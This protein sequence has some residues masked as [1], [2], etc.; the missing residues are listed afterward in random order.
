[1]GEQWHF[2]WRG[3]QGG[4][5]SAARLRQMADDGRLL[6]TDLVW[7]KGM[8]T[9]APAGSLHGLFRPR[10]VQPPPPPPVRSV[11]ATARQAYQ[12]LQIEGN[13]QSWGFWLGVIAA[14]VAT[15]FTWHFTANT[16]VTI[17]ASVVALAVGAYVGY[18]FALV[19]TGLLVLALLV[20][21]VLLFVH[22]Q[23]AKQAQEE[24]VF[25]PNSLETT[26]LWLQA[27]NQKVRE[28]DQKNNQVLSKE[29]LE[30][31][32]RELAR[33]E[34]AEVK[35][36]ALVESVG[37]DA[38]TLQGPSVA[39]GLS[40]TFEMTTET[41]RP[42]G[43]AGARPLVL[44]ITPERGRNLARGQAVQFTGRVLVCR[45]ERSGGGLTFTLVV[46]EAR[47]AE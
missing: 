12:G 20:G 24:A 23:K 26:V 44:P 30:G 9:W 16:A 42:A 13:A 21:G 35:W 39:S 33:A 47:L 34:G 14:V 46:A 45:A 15:C 17:A 32:N 37:P 28:V 4:P 11:R 10:P 7:T 2:T 6:P 36:Q 22:Y 5:V 19:L 1:M 8:A 40:L 27:R 25:D 18:R 38:V 31:V 43:Q 3:K 29:A 41:A